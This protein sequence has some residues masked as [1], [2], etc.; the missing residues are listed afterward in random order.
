MEDIMSEPFLGQITLVAFNFAPKDYAWCDGEEM[1]IGQNP[2]LFT[3]IGTQFGG[4]GRTSFNLP[5]LRGRTPVHPGGQVFQQGQKGGAETVALDKGAMATHTH[6]FFATESDGELHGAFPSGTKVLA[7]AELYGPTV[8]PQ[9]IYGPPG[10]LISL[11][12]DTSTPTGGGSAHNN[13]Q[14]S[15]VIGFVIALEGLFPRRS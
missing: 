3:L 7:T 13:L 14:P 15:L 4:D 1:P 6:G 5:D 11:K 8:E 9:N 12:S 10:N 2:A